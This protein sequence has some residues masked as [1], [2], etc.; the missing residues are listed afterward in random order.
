MKTSDHHLIEPLAH[1]VAGIAL[2]DW[3]TGNRPKAIYRLDVIQGSSG[4]PLGNRT[5]RLWAVGTSMTPL[6]KVDGRKRSALRNARAKAVNQACVSLGGLWGMGCLKKLHKDSVAPLFNLAG[7]DLDRAARLL[8]PVCPSRKTGGHIAVA[9]IEAMT[10]LPP[11]PNY[12]TAIHAMATSVL[13]DGELTDY[14][15]RLGQILTTY[16]F[17][18]LSS[19]S[20]LV[21]WPQN[22]KGYYAIAASPPPNPAE[23][24]EPN[25]SI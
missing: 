21:P 5:K 6:A 2:I 10:N 4:Q 25:A 17:D 8:T 12:Q 23:R 1:Y 22:E 19:G 16:N 9:V 3:L 14:E 15:G 7:C 20:S 24:G 18:R 11:N 13:R